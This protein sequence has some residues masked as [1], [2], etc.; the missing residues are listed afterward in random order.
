V[1]WAAKGPRFPGIRFWDQPFL[2]APCEMG[3]GTGV[4]HGALKVG[5][6]GE[7]PVAAGAHTHP[8]LVRLVGGFKYHGI[9]GL[10]WPLA[11]L[12]HQ[13]FVQ[14]QVKY[15][16]VDAVVPVALHR[17]RQRS[18]GF[19]Q[20]E[21]LCRGLHE[22]AGIPVVPR[23]LSRFRVT[24]QQAKLTSSDQRMRNLTNA[25]KAR[26]PVELLRGGSGR[27]PRVCLVDDLVTSG[28]TVRAAAA[29]LK[30]S[31]WPVVWVLALGLSAEIEN[32]GRQVDTRNGGF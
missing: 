26:T 27:V 32:P 11:R 2:C 18:R 10:G 28:W 13:A 21:V 12:L 22:L 31:G 3:L 4:V 14:G 30:A 25:F 24:D 5:S 29:V 16:P 7:L 17:R 8:D 15:G 20:A 23:A 19:N 6:S 1:S 9:R